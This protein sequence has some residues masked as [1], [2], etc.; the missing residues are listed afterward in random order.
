[1]AKVSVKSVAREGKRAN[2]RQASKSQTTRDSFQNFPLGL[3][4]GTNN[5]SSANTYGYNPITRNRI[6]IDWM[7]RG[8]WSAGAAVD[9]IAD[10][11]TREGRR[12]CRSARSR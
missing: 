2:S 10:D 4:I 1:M 12:R 3:G 8:S 11:M 5:A 9:V 7:Y 6:E